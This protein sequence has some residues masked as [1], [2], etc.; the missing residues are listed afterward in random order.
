MTK[1]PVSWYKPGKQIT[2]NDK[3][4][5]GYIYTLEAKYGILDFKAQL[6]PMQMLKL[7]VFEGKYLND[8]ENEFPAEWYTAARAADKLRPDKPDVDVNLFKIK[9]RL[10]LQE[11]RKRKWIPIAPGDQDVRG[12]FQWYCRYFIGRRMPVIDAI[13]IG[14]Y[15]AFVRHRAQILKSL[16]DMPANKRPKTKKELL[17]HRPR[18]RQALLQWAWNPFVKV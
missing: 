8:C 5:A 2:V 13:Q 11:W 3:M 7:G 1:K 10:S 16:K 12:W 15:K 6:T 14:R 18:Q 4:Q 17:L 9:S